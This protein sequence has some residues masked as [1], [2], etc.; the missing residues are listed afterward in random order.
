M[1]NN[2]KQY[3]KNPGLNLIEL[4]AT[5]SSCSACGTENAIDW[6]GDMKYPHEAVVPNHGDGRWIPVSVPVKCSNCMLD[7]HHNIPIIDRD[8][9]WGL[10]GDEAGRI[11]EFNG[12][13]IHFFCLT[14]IGLHRSKHEL[15]KSK[16]NK[17]KLDARP[18]LAPETWTHHFTEIWSDSGPE[19]RFAFPGVAEKINYGQR[20]AKMIKDL[21]PELVCFN[22]SSAIVLGDARKDNASAI[23]TQKE[24]LFKQ[25]LLA[26]LDTMRINKKGVIWHFD[27][28]KDSTSGERTEG[29]ALECFLGLQYTRLFTYLAAGIYIPEPKF[30]IPGS[31]YLLEVA[32][33]ISFC[34]ARD[35]LKISQGKAGE[36]PS[37]RLGKIYCY[38]IM[39]DGQPDYAFEMGS[40]FLKRYFPVFK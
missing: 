24:D 7:Y 13:R 38:R 23:K 26:T 15:I 34:I 32:D 16:L 35:F 12:K 18:D 17:F 27:N 11:V 14:L 30:M 2:K 6:L 28:I 8:G 4:E 20:F 10:Y 1:A 3:R 37:A 31:H 9:T 19:R 40:F 25:A 29:W 33:F 21:S 36:I 22:F 39:E 5:T